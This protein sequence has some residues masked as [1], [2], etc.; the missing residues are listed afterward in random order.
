MSGWGSS[1]TRSIRPCTAP[2]MQV[3]R[4]LPSLRRAQA[5]R[6]KPLAEVNAV[7]KQDYDNAV[8]QAA[9]T[10]AAADTARINLVYTRLLSPI[11]GRIGRSSVTEGALVTERPGAVAGDGAAA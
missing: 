8:A 4:P 10:R 7:S 5:E 9:Q 11:A 3:P 6:F 1:S 2:P